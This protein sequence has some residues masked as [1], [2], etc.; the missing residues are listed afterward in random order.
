MGMIGAFPSSLPLAKILDETSAILGRLAGRK[1]KTFT[2]ADLPKPAPAAAGT[3]QVVEYPYASASNPGPVMY[4]WPA[5]RNLDDT[6]HTLMALF[7]D[8][9][10]GDEST[11]LYKKLIDGKT[12][13][14]DLGASGVWSYTTSDEGQP[15]YIG[16]SGVKSDKLDD[17]TIGD[18][19]TLIT[20]EMQRIA[21]LP[22]GDP[23]LVAFV[24]KVKSRVIDAR[25]R[26]AKFLDTP[27]GFGIRRTGSAWDDLLVDLNRRGGFKKSLTMRPALA[28]I[29]Q[30]LAANGNPFKDR[31][32][33]W[34][35]TAT[36]FAV[37]AKPSP[38][39]RAQLDAERKS[40]IDAE[41]AQL[42]SQYG[43]KDAPSTLARYAQDYDAET[44]K[45]E[46][47]QKAA[48]LPPLVDSPPMTLDDGLDYKQTKVGDVT[49]FN[50]TFESMASARVALSMNVRGEV[51]DGDMLYLAALPTLLDGSGIIENGKPVPADEMRE[52]M[53]KEILGVSIYY[54]ANPR[55]GRIELG[56]A[57]S[58]NGANETKLAIGWMKRLMLSPDW[59]IE[60]L[61][62]LRDLVDQSVTGLR[63]AM[64]GAEEGWVD[65]PRDAWRH[66]DQLEYLHTSSF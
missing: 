18:V 50:A 13:V 59:R 42:Q 3:I 38:A 63:E 47:T 56:V 23:E 61:P 55:T 51:A 66:Q 21:S 65:D 33:Q 14:M 7:L 10:A 62:R 24:D 45:L 46:D 30:I 9:L 19:R 16:L 53:R 5:T 60:N 35:L 27:P 64:L 20:G 11:P 32:A 49:A 57:G 34:G 52:R 1:G 54:G 36:P 12:R 44:K 39:R 43:T 25:R 15:V 2:E 17:K 48:E 40:R 8:S 31:I 6:E 41:L 26:Y 4:A 37:A 28:A 29:E 58:G 22:D